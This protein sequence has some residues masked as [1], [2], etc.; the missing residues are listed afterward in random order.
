MCIDKPNSSIEMQV[1]HIS[2][3][4]TPDLHTGF[5]AQ[6][7]LWHTVDE[8]LGQATLHVLSTYFQN[9][10]VSIAITRR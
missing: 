8:K 6:V 9:I 10:C 7:V 4:F 5:A 1:S 2:V 3:R